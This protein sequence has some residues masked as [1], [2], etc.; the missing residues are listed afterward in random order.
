ET[1]ARKKRLSCPECGSA[2]V[3]RALMA[4]AIGK[5]QA[6]LQPAAPDTVRLAAADPRQAG[7]VEAL[8]KVRAYVTENADYV[9]NRFA[10]EARRLHDGESAARGI[11]G[12]ASPEEARSLIED[13]IEF[14]PLPAL[15]E[16]RN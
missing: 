4:P 13:G 5:A 2:K 8:R 16:D 1:E 10:A 9:G 7:L 3:E 14:Y 15:P 11:Y 12:E 6:E